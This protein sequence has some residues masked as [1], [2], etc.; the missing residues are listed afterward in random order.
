MPIEA[1]SSAGSGQST[2][3]TADTQKAFRQADFLKIMLAEVVNQNPLD[4]QDT[5]KLVDNMRKLQELANSTYQKFRT[6]ITWA[7]DLTGKSVSVQ[8]QALTPDE[9]QTQKDSGLKPD[10]GYQAV[11]GRVTGFRVVKE[12]VYVTVGD[13]DY[14][15]DNIKQIIPE[16]NDSRQ[17]AEVANAV[18]GRKVFWT[19]DKG[20]AASGTA[21]D[22]SFSEDG[23]VRVSI[24]TA[25]VVPFSKITR[26]GA[27]TP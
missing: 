23:S 27:A 2:S 7:Q 21:T 12:A 24:G 20:V 15:V 3:Q 5:G 22:V 18:I 17:L 19:D 25:T 6:D 4:P 13:K 26:I 9:A 1:T 8:Q 14:P 16:R 11:T 10:V